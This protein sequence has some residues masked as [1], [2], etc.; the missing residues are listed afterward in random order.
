MRPLNVA[1][2]PIGRRRLSCCLLV[3][4][5]LLSWGDTPVSGDR[6]AG[7]TARGSHT[8][9]T[10]TRAS[11][12]HR[13]ARCWFQST[14]TP[15]SQP[16]GSCCQKVARRLRSLVMTASL[17]SPCH[18]RLVAD[19]HMQQQRTVPHRLEAPPVPRRVVDGCPPSSTGR[20]SCRCFLHGARRPP[21]GG[22]RP[23]SACT[24]KVGASGRQASS[25]VH[26]LPYR[27]PGLSC[28]SH[29]VRRGP[30]SLPPM[31]G[32]QARGE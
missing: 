26:S 28:S 23:T 30:P 16:L 20:C 21:D 15:I 8:C 27:M 10:D 32:G 18:A 3:A 12:Q 14:Q 1:V 4:V 22:G 6:S 25:K 19:R 5:L 29:Q 9:A 2:I 11:G 7:F 17:P 24:S 31:P 13:P